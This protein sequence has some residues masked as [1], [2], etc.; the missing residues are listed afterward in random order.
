MDKEIKAK[1]EEF[2]KEYGRRELSMDEMDQ[3]S[4]GGDG[5]GYAAAIDG[6]AYR[7]DFILNMGRTMEQTFGFDVAA[8]ALCKMFGL[9]PVN[10]KRHSADID[11]LVNRIYTIH[12][13]VQ[14][15][16]SSF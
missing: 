11:A 2:V 15:N 9:D 16:G 6:K 5:K 7:E 4:G 12:E 10:E 13:R 1:V 3:V 14:D 8:D